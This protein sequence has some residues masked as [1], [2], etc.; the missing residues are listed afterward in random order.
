MAEGKVKLMAV[1]DIFLETK[2]NINPF[3]NVKEAFSGKDVLWGNLETVLS[4]Q[5]EEAEKAVQLYTSPDKVKYLK[6]SGFDVLNIANNHIM[7]LGLE[8]FNETLDM[9]HRS[10]LTFIGAS[11]HK[12]TQRHKIVKRKGIKLVFLGYCE[13]G[14]SN[15]KEGVF[16]NRI[17][18]DSIVADISA[19]KAHCDIVIVSLHWGIENV[20][21]P[22]PKQINLA[23]RLID[24][25]AALILGHHPHV[26]QGIERYKNGLIVYSLGNFQFITSRERNK[27]SIILSAEISKNGIED[28]RIIPAKIDE[29]NIPWVMNDEKARE[30][31]SFVEE[32]S[33]PITEGRV[34]EDWW[35]EEIAREHIVGNMKAWI[36]RIKKYGIK[37]LLQCIR[38]H[39][40]PFIVKCYIGLLRRWLRKKEI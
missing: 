14:F 36:I 6:E 13:C 23:R 19:L 37:H 8:G 24:S 33:L 9:L 21:Y 12:F 29:D 31:V 7:D 39:M 11:N 18:E 34:K 35:F 4:D 27:Q 5:G 30:M 2:D 20:F 16:I 40:S 22:S 26:V 25:G 3:V 17:D 10:N 1:G 15:Y 28:Y 32:I 38:W